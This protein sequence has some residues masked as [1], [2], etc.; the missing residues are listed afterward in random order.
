M[1]EILDK[2]FRNKETN[3]K[4]LVKGYCNTSNEVIFY[5]EYIDQ[6][7]TM[8]KEEFYAKYEEVKE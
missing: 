6:T 3:T 4:V 7:V 1:S 2:Y 8:P 5:V